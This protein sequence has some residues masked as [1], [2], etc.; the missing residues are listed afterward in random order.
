MNPGSNNEMDEVN[1]YPVGFHITASLGIVVIPS[2]NPFNFLKR[3]WKIFQG[4]L[5]SFLNCISVHL[6]SM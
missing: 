2:M 6:H 3:D 4:G 1:W 5:F